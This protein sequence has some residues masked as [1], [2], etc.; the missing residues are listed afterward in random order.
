M[1][2]SKKFNRS[3]RRNKNTR[4]KGH[5]EHKKHNKHQWGD[6]FDDDDFDLVVSTIDIYH[7][8]SWLTILPLHKKYFIFK[9]KIYVYP[10]LEEV[11]A[12]KF[13]E[14]LEK[15]GYIFKICIHIWLSRRIVFWPK[16]CLSLTW[17]IFLKKP[18]IVFWFVVSE[19]LQ[20]YYKFYYTK[21][22]II[23][24]GHS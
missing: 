21:N 3:H 8:S 18:N 17:T 20:F 13:W 7:S 6:E 14:Y 2:S 12:L 23:L 4:R 24:C 9:N 22:F 11:L 5:K 15:N 16:I 1:R 19:A 10:F